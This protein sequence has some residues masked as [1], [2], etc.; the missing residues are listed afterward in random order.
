LKNIYCFLDAVKMKDVVMVGRPSESLLP[1]T[2]RLSQT[3]A[4]TE[5]NSK[6][7]D[8]RS[9]IQMLSGK[10]HK[11]HSCKICGYAGNLTDVTRHMRTHTGER[12]FS[13]PFCSSR[14]SLRGNMIKH[15]ARK[16]GTFLSRYIVL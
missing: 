15:L 4:S 11:K 5:N 14:F 6:A 8:I 9:S 10:F 16:H 13:C 1:A 2:M 12:P 3:A 7:I